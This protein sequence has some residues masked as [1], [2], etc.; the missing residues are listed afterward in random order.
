MKEFFCKKTGKES[1]KATRVTVATLALLCLLFLLVSQ[2]VSEGKRV[3]SD[4]IAV[5]EA[6]LAFN[7][8]DGVSFPTKLEFSRL[9]L[10]NFLGD[11]V[12]DSGF[13]LDAIKNYSKD[14]SFL[15]VLKKGS[16]WGAR[17]DECQGC[18]VL[19]FER[20]IELSGE[21]YVL[22][23][24]ALL[25]RFLFANGIINTLIE[26]GAFCIIVFMAFYW[27]EESLRGRVTN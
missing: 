17:F 9:T 3:L 14:K 15:K 25:T 2:R 10:L 22:R 5:A 21:V 1:L 23:A 26:L 16:A 8:D 6:F 7:I 24:S 20:R 19:F 11:A 18:F 12:A 4:E 13:S 27:K